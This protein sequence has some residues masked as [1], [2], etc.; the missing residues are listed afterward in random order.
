MATI[1]MIQL[2]LKPS[3]IR[4]EQFYNLFCT[5]CCSFCN[6]GLHE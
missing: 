1:V 3:N 2:E 5:L 6:S 4:T